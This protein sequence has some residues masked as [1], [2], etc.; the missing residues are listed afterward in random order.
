MEEIIASQIVGLG[1]CPVFDWGASCTY[2]NWAFWVG[3]VV[4]AVG[5]IVCF[6][7]KPMQPQ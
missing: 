6:F 4:G 2:W 1:T 7:L 5:G 3:V